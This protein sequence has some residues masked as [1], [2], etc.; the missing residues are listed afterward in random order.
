M[1]KDFRLY[2]S[3]IWPLIQEID[4]MEIEQHI[5]ASTSRSASRSMAEFLHSTRFPPRNQIVTKSNSNEPKYSF[6]FS[7][8]LIILMISGWLR[9]RMKSMKIP[10]L[11][12][13]LYTILVL[14][15]GVLIVYFTSPKPS[16]FASSWVGDGNDFVF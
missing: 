8:F 2:F 6:E 15:I 12:F 7:L 11:I 14:I 16:T 13:L 1:N 4:F 5:P 9:I 10:A 3:V